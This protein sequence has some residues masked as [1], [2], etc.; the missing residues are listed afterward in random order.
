[1]G[2]KIW[3]SCGVAEFLRRAL[4]CIAVRCGAAARGRDLELRVFNGA[5]VAAG[6]YLP[7]LLVPARAE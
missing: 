5:A 4:H 1:M 7:Y 6:T 2:L 3:R